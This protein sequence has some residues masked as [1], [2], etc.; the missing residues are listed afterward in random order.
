M[1]EFGCLARDS[2]LPD[3]FSV[4]GSF[5]VQMTASLSSLNVLKHR[6]GLFNFAKVA[7]FVLSKVIIEMR[8]ALRYSTCYANFQHL[9]L[10]QVNRSY[11]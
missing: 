8:L 11:R 5:Y 10:F 4:T 2:N 3:V 7:I 9:H 6:K 1:K